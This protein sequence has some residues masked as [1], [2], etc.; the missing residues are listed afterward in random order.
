MNF[1][2]TRATQV[3]ERIMTKLRQ[4]LPELT[5][6]HYNRTYEAIWNEL[7]TEFGE[8]QPTNDGTRLF[9]GFFD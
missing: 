2:P 4:K 3:T 8:T 5:T 9:A 1:P 7:T 6:Y